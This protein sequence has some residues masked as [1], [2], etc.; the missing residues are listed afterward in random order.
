MRVP[1]V[2]FTLRRLMAAVAASAVI[3]GG[4]RLHRQATDYRSRAAGSAQTLA[5]IRNG[6]WGYRLVVGQDGRWHRVIDRADLLSLIRYHTELRTKY[7]RAAA[8]PW[9]PVEPDPPE[10]R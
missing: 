8:R 3:L 2:R 7:E 10:P 5:L 1:R 9:L 4:V 6:A